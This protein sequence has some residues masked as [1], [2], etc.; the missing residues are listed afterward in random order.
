M[1]LLL[2]TVITEHCGVTI[3]SHLK[4]LISSLPLEAWQGL[5]CCA[6]L[7][8]CCAVE[9]FSLADWGTGAIKKAQTPGCRLGLAT[10]CPLPMQAVP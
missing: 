4:V 7:G 2:Q 10:S 6:V 3:T 5:L 9:Q 8:P 1:P